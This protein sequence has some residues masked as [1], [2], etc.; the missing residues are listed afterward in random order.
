M[1][2]LACVAAD[3]ANLNSFSLF[4]LGL[5]WLTSL[6]FSLDESLVEEEHIHFKQGNFRGHLH[7][8]NK[9]LTN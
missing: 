7:Q 8:F 2:S 1:Q 5:P 6:H 9:H 3:V 4:P